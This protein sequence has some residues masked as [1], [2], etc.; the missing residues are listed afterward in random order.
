MVECGRHPLSKNGV[1]VRT[2]YTLLVI[3]VGWAILDACSSAN[4]V[5]LRNKDYLWQPMAPVAWDQTRIPFEMRGKPWPEVLRWFAEQTGLELVSPYPIPEGT[6]TFTN[7]DGSQNPRMYSLVDV[8][9]I[10]NEVLQGSTK[11]TLVRGSNTLAVFPADDCVNDYPP[12]PRIRLQDLP[13][14]GRTEI[15]LVEIKIDPDALPQSRRW[16]REQGSVTQLENGRFLMRTN[17]GTLVL[18]MRVI[19]IED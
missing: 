13:G 19:A 8:F 18:L 2:N 1:D 9:D 14:R 17:V 4:A 6:F 16:L 10:I 7:P 5:P 11:H 15:V 3:V 12:I